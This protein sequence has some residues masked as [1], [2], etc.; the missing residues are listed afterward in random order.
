MLYGLSRYFLRVAIKH[1]CILGVVVDVVWVVSWAKYSIFRP[2]RVFIFSSYS[3]ASSG[4]LDVVWG[5]L[6]IF[7]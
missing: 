3:D 4:F 2:R 6:V 5:C 7:S 1:V